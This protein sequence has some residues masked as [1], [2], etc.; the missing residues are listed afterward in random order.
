MTGMSTKRVVALAAAALVVLA[1][2]AGVY[3]FK[4]RTVAAVV[5]DAA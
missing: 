1:A 4:A 5:V 2:G 3:V